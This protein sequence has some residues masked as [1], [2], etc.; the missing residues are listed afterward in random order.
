MGVNQKVYGPYGMKLKQIQY[1]SYQSEV[2]IYHF[3]TYHVT[4]D[5][6]RRHLTRKQ[7]GY[8][9]SL[10][11]PDEMTG[12]HHAEG[13]VIPNGCIE[14]AY[15]P[16]AFSHSGSALGF[17]YWVGKEVEWMCFDGPVLE[18]VLAEKWP[19]STGCAKSPFD[20][21]AYLEKGQKKGSV[22]G[23]NGEHRCWNESLRLAGHHE[24]KLKLKWRNREA[25]EA[26]VEMEKEK[27][28]EMDG[29]KPLQS[30]EE[31][32]DDEYEDV[33]EAV[34]NYGSIEYTEDDEN[35]QPRRPILKR[36]TRTMYDYYY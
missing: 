11:G 7:H 24:V 10:Y 16:K 12:I 19:R 26:S 27:E 14:V 13:D 23:G 18:G 1:R 36:P 31:E 22:R 5:Q 25:S 4:V 30:M 20:L 6:L 8:V 17:R 34:E 35:F 3:N 15:L 33:V 2:Y 9:A 32:E 21:V 28:K 29:E